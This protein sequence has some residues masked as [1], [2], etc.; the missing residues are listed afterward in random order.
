MCR[1]TAANYKGKFEDLVR[2][3]CHEMKRTFE[4]RLINEVDTQ[5]FRQFLH[6]GCKN[7]LYEPTEANNPLAEPLIFTQFIPLHF[8]NDLCY[9]MTDPVQLKKVLDEKLDEYN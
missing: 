4:D 6:D 7:F 9:I 3:W 8:G 2:L 5:Y 1:S